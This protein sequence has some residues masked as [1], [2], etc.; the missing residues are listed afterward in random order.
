MK[1]RI[2]ILSLVVLLL[3][4]RFV[5]ATRSMPRVG[6][7]VAAP[8]VS[9]FDFPERSCLDRPRF[10]LFRYAPPSGSGGDVQGYEGRIL[11]W[12]PDD[13]G[14]YLPA[15]YTLTIMLSLTDPAGHPI[16]APP[17]GLSYTHQGQNDIVWS[18]PSQTPV[19]RKK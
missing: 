13:P 10:R 7:N 8:V 12:T 19:L 14:A 17:S 16:H 11:I 15:D 4:P 1:Y 2:T 6:E 18:K 9:R 5:H 3:A